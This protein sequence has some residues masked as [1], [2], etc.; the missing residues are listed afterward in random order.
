[1]VALEKDMI[2]PLYPYHLVWI[3]TNACNA[4]C[5][6][7]S[8][9]AAKRLPEE[10]STEQAKHLFSHL[11]DIGVFDI[12]I[13]GGEPLTRPDIFELIEH[14]RAVGLK[15]GIGSN[16]STITEEKVLKLR[17]AGVSRLQI[18]IDG[19]EEIHDLARRWTGLFQKSKHAIALG[20]KGGL[21]VHVCMTL[22]KLNYRVME[23]VI[24]LCID[25]GVKDLIFPGSYPRG[26]VINHLILAKRNGE[27]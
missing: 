27:K 14:M 15:I 20:I 9:A 13:S 16:G 6:H 3:A 24:Q 8:T 7:C 18:S 17:A 12:A 26:V 25:W 22:H 23:E 1:M 11:A 10:L 4:R 19:T 5:V 21:N 2:V